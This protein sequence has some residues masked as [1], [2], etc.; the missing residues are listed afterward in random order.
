MKK[1]AR[2][3]TSTPVFDGILAISSFRHA[4]MDGRHPGP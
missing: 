3:S 4:G 2:R 1:E